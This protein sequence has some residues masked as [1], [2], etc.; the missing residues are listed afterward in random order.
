MLKVLILDFDGV[1]VESVDIK[2]AAFRELFKDRPCV[3]DI[4]RYHLQNNA[5]SRFIKFK[6]IYNNILHEE[7]N[8]NIEGILGDKFTQIVFQKVVECHLCPGAQEFLTIFSSIYPIYLAS[9]TPQEELEKIIE[10]RDLRHYFKEVW[11]TPPGNKLKFINRALKIEKA[12]P[13]EALY[14]GDMVEDFR[15]AQETGVAFV[16]RRYAESFDGL[17]VPVFPNMEGIIEWIKNWTDRTP[18]G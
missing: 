11:G 3:D 6:H 5:L 8:K 4:I 9:A 10:A 14:I 2:T 12:K 18:G 1:V 13:A 17:D 7:Y 15:V 16:G